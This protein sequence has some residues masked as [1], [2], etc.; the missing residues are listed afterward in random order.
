MT[1]SERSRQLAFDLP[2]RPAFG[3]DDFLVSAC[4]RAAIAM[5]DQWPHWTNPVQLLVGAEGSGKTHLAQVWQN[6]SGA[7]LI[8]ENAPLER[9]LGVHSL[10]IDDVDRRSY[11]AR[12]L[13]HLINTAHEQQRSTLLTARARPADWPYALPDLIS[14]LKALAPVEIGAPDDALLHA[15]LV[16]HFDDRQMEIAPNLALYLARRI[17]RSLAAARETV[18]A[19]DQAALSSRR[20]VTRRL[21]AEILKD[22]WEGSS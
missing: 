19:L 18:E 20:P 22:R 5:I 1:A 9:A 6:A 8:D 3:A 4:N 17:D 14:R 16:K 15:V 2:H 21:A 7:L 12:F 11:D 10:V 13:F